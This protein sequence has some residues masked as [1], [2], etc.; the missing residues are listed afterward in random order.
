[1]RQMLEAALAVLVVLSLSPPPAAA[2]KRTLP[3]RIAQARYVALGYD[4]GDRFLSETAAIASPDVLPEERRAL[5]AIHDDL[6]RWG[7]Y[8][9]TLRPEDAE[10]LIA[11]RVGRRG[12]FGGSTIAGGVANGTGGYGGAFDSAGGV[13]RGSSFN[14]EISSNTDM[15]TVYDSAG[16]RVGAQLWRVQ[17]GGGL[18]GD[19]PK[20]FQQFRADVESAPA[21]EA[22]EPAP[23]KPE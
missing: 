5:Q 2:G 21:P 23:G 8:V 9:V 17:K 11:V 1:M 13:R 22:K 19:P 18:A 15:L 10:L 3:A 4:L 14:A 6:Q 16:G 12:S 7:K 20:L